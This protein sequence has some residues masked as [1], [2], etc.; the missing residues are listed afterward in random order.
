MDD[1]AYGDMFKLQCRDTSSTDLLRMYCLTQRA[2][3]S[4]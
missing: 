2:C 1:S 4:S 3:F